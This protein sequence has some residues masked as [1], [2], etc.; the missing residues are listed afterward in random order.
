MSTMSLRDY[1]V[2]TVREKIME[3]KSRIVLALDKIPFV[4]GFDEEKLYSKCVD[5]LKA[6]EP[7]IVGVKVGLPLVVNYGFSLIEKIV[8]KY[9]KRLIFIYDGKV[10]DV[11][12]VNEVVAKRVYEVGFD[13]I[14]VH[15]MVGYEGGVEGVVNVARSIGKG[16]LVLAAMSHR[17]AIRLNSLT[18]DIST[19]FCDV[20]GVVGYVLPATYPSLIKIAR[21]FLG[22]DY[23]ILSPG[24]GAQ[25][26]F[27]GTAVMF[28][29]D[30]EIIG[31]SIYESSV[32]R[33]EVIKLS[34]I[35]SRLC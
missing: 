15:G 11:A 34:K 28:G 30:L 24:V 33:E 2:K 5:L 29:A 8:Q 26:A 25:G 16:I 1:W 17:G 18:M 20:E 7:F 3:K 22:E 12:H 4:E 10:A 13:L 23:L 9:R 14:I 31:R 35:Y 21:E 32:P 19:E 6:V 27:F